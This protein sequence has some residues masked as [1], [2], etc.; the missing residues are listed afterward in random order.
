MMQ[1]TESF[2]HRY[3][4]NHKLPIRLISPTF[5]HLQAEV[6]NA[7]GLTHRKTYYFLILMLEGITRHSV[8]L[9]QFEVG[10]NELLFILPIR[11]MSCHRRGTGKITSKL[12]LMRNVFLFYQDNIRF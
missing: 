1:I 2:L 12:D 6:A 5:G 4:Q 11:F 10:A 8:D 9:R 3:S 7:Y